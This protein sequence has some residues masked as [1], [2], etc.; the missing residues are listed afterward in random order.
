MIKVF[1]GFLMSPVGHSFGGVNRTA[2]SN[3]DDCIDRGYFCT[4]SVTS[5]NCTT[6][7]FCL[8]LDKVP[9]WCFELR[10]FSACWMRGVFEASEEPVMMKALEEE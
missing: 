10:S 1:I 8:M 9:A 4:T 3:A 5:S 7:A 2:A 6:G